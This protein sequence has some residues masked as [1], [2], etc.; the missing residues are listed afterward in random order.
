MGVSVI[1][2]TYNRAWCIGRAVSSVLY[3]E[4][5]EYEVIVVDDGSTDDTKDKLS[6]FGE[7][8]KVIS[9]DKNRGVSCARNTG[10]KNSRY[11]F[12][13]FLD[14]DDFWLPKK[15]LAQVEFFE[16]NPD[17]VICQTQEIW[18]RKGKRVNPKKKHLK[19]SG[20]I[21]IP[22]LR[23]CLV[24]PSAV[25]LRKSLFDEIGLFDEDLPVCE[26]YDMWL[27]ISCKYPVYLIDKPLVVKTGGH[28]DQLSSKYWGMDRFR[29]Y[30]LVKLIKETSLNDKQYN[31]VIKELKYKCTIY[32]NGCIKRGRI[33]EGRFYLDLPH[34]VTKD[35]A[36]A[37]LKL[38][39]LLFQQGHL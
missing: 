19:P 29:I 16:K 35:I 23:L 28:T 15:L 10:I 7:R 1:I 2:P 11:C 33:L 32:G 38:R 12:I 25:M 22:S 14:S 6:V 26:D 31:A 27:R 18:I 3:Q 37:F 5:K 4:F 17:A 24:S 8:I 13:A 20:D 34:L 30:A 21:F 9:H 36:T 39:H